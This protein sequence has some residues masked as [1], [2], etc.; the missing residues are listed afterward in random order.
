MMHDAKI[1]GSAKLRV[2]LRFAAVAGLGLAGCDDHAGD[3]KV[4]IGANPAARAAAISDAADANCKSRQDGKRSP[5]A[6]LR[7]W[8]HALA[9]GQ[10]PALLYVL[11]NGDVLVSAMVR[12]RRSTDQRTSSPA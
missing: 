3:P 6:A 7:V 11:P 4:Q 5:P 1:A 9:T 8:V 2:S 12:K 10:H